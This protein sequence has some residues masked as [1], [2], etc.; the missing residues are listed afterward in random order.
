MNEEATNN[1]DRGD[2]WK[3]KLP[4]FS[5]L[6]QAS[7]TAKTMPET[8]S[9][10][11]PTPPKP[12]ISKISVPKPPAPMPEA[13]VIPPPPSPESDDRYRENVPSNSIPTPPAPE[14]A[15]VKDIAESRMENASQ[16]L[17]KVRTFSDDI[18]I[19]EGKDP[20][21]HSIDYNKVSP[22]ED[23]NRFVKRH[24]MTGEVAEAKHRNEVV[25]KLPEM[26][27]APAPKPI[28]SSGFDI[29]SPRGVVNS[30]NKNLDSETPRP[31]GQMPIRRTL[32]P[33]APNATFKEPIESQSLREA[34]AMHKEEPREK[35][36]NEN[37]HII[38][39]IRTLRGDVNQVVKDQNITLA[40]IAIKEDQKRREEARMVVKESRSASRTIILLV[41]LLL[42]LGGSFAIWFTLFRNSEVPVVVKDETNDIVNFLS[43][44]V[45]TIIEVNEKAPA[46][47]QNEI[48]AE[49]KKEQRL[50]HLK[51]VILVNAIK[52]Q[53]GEVVLREIITTQEMFSALN[54]TV[55]EKLSRLVSERFMLG[56]YAYTSK[57]PYLILEAEDYSTIFA[58]M[59]VWERSGLER[60][61]YRSLKGTA[62]PNDL[63]G[64]WRDEVM[65]NLDVRVFRGE[66]G[67][68]Y[69]FWSFID[70]DKTL[71]ITTNR[72]TLLEVRTRF[73]S[74]SVV[75]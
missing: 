20:E 6:N 23:V 8:S 41:V 39:P 60:N 16:S 32:I 51:E 21:S 1:I 44:D 33:P 57:E 71:V 73:N 27:K 52:N 69:L 26:P 72:S 11:L 42:I 18:L 54:L 56:I 74:R 58:Q 53:N 2:D 75:R 70:A 12:S 59:L 14:K 9:A 19:A 34:R 36:N 65:D 4:G 7:P 48:E 38:T 30:P 28:T 64:I 22:D 29:P 49:L 43:S 24:S 40:N 5:D 67:N 62:L 3:S 45:E 31:L 61:I 55:P 66:D 46:T 10:D 63:T 13:K 50:G 37:D 15:G 35:N 68:S 17:R 25:S 47:I